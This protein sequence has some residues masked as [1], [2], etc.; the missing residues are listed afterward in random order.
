MVDGESRSEVSSP[1]EGMG[2]K[3]IRT[4]DAPRPARHTDHSSCPVPRRAGP[5]ALS[6]RLSCL[7]LVDYGLR[8]INCFP[9]LQRLAHRNRVMC[10]IGEFLAPP[11]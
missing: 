6:G 7:A 5:F 10:T 1:R 11:K 4:T 2:L 8:T 3:H 9:N